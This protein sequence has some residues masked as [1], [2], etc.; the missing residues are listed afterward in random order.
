[1]FKISI[2]GEKVKIFNKFIFIFLASSFLSLNGMEESS[3]IHKTGPKI[4]VNDTSREPEK[5]AEENEVKEPKKP[6]SLKAIT[7]LNILE[8]IK[9]EQFSW[10]QLEPFEGLSRYVELFH[11]ADTY[12]Q[13]DVWQRNL[14]HR[15]AKKV[16]ENRRLVYQLIGSNSKYV[17]SFVAALDDLMEFLDDDRN[18]G[19]SGNN[20]IE[21]ILKLIL[22]KQELLAI[23]N[24]SEKDILEINERYQIN[25]KEIKKWMSYL[26]DLILRNN[27]PNLLNLILGLDLITDETRIYLFKELL[28]TSNYSPELL[29]L[30]SDK[31]G[32]T[33]EEYTYIIED[34]FLSILWNMR[35]EI[36][37]V[38]IGYFMGLIKISGLDEEIINKQ[39]YA[40]KMILYLCF[41]RL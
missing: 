14:L 11:I 17:E 26:N 6:L 33:K 37:I 24:Q 15:L 5:K 4:E 41:V 40:Y 28:C 39:V 29:R 22:N 12:F 34:K 2:N 3:D 25:I 10:S 8:Q 27:L 1:M 35:K 36:D 18:T 20:F 21:F 31:A 38:K 23:G 32:L 13:P 19:L 9:S 7:A 16:L 30:L